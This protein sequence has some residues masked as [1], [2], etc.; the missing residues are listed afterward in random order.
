MKDSGPEMSPCPGEDRGAELGDTLS[1][2]GLAA[3]NG[4]AQAGE[5]VASQLEKRPRAKLSKTGRMRELG[6]SG[7]P[8][9]AESLG[10][11]RR[12]EARLGSGLSG[13]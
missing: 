9:G 4:E 8:G 12:G 7:G 11:R 1:G 3:R 10:G 6:S 2:Y 5:M 13:N